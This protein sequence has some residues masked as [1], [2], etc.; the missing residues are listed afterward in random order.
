MVIDATFVGLVHLLEG[1]LLDNRADAIRLEHIFA[2]FNDHGDLCHLW[3]FLVDRDDLLDGL[4][5]N[6][7]LHLGHGHLVK[8][9]LILHHFDLLHEGNKD[10]DL[11]LLSLGDLL[12]DNLSGIL[13]LGRG[14]AALGLAAS[15]AGLANTTAVGLVASARW[16]RYGDP[17]L[18]RDLFPPD[19]SLNPVV[20]SLLLLK[21]LDGLLNSLDLLD[22]LRVGNHDGLLD[23]AGLRIL[24]GGHDQLDILP[25]DGLVDTFSDLCH[26]FLVLSAGAREVVG[27][28]A[29]A[30]DGD[31]GGFNG[32]GLGAC[33]EECESEELYKGEID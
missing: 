13:D 3:H 10:G 31:G 20:D 15:A 1:E 19:F 6:F 27:T 25:V 11:D 23:L 28:A 24:G 32:L 22:D 9:V 18:F 17:H 26:N 5:H 14:T 21:L 30:L 8:N 4:Q 16:L 7:G 29:V 2:N 12:G 33:G